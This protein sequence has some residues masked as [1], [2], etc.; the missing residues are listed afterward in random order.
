MHDFLF[1]SRGVETPA[2]SKI[3]HARGNPASTATASSISLFGSCRAEAERCGSPIGWQ[4]RSLYLDFGDT[5]VGAAVI[6]APLLCPTGTT[7]SPYTRIP[8]SLFF[9]DF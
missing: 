6:L 1:D 8:I 3:T 2:N 4:G 9:W 7:T 5:T